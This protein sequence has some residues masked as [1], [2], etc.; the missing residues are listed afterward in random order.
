M[1][2][3]TNEAQAP[4]SKFLNTILLLLLGLAL[5]WL[6]QYLMEERTPRP[7]FRVGEESVTIIPDRTIGADQVKISVFG[8]SQ[9]L[10]STTTISIDSSFAYAFPSTGDKK[11]RILQEYLCKGCLITCCDNDAYVEPGTLGVPIVVADVILRQNT[12]PIPTATSPVTGAASNPEYN[13][14]MC[15]WGTDT[16]V[17]GD[18]TAN[19]GTRSFLYGG[20]GATYPDVR[21]LTVTD[22]TNTASLY[23]RTVGTTP[24]P[25]EYAQYSSGDNFNCSLSAASGF[26]YIGGTAPTSMVLYSNPTGTFSFIVKTT[27]GNEMTSGGTLAYQRIE[28]TCPGNWTVNQARTIGNCSNNAE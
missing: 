9:N 22:G 2:T 21:K 7:T 15:V 14:C 1:S 5:G 16:P 8:P 10:L 26:S 4:K 24:V 3:H 27:R 11:L 12:A 18:G 28:I 17:A 25:G 23:I 6:A 20:P 19:I 13:W